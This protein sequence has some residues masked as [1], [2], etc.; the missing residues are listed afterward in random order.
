MSLRSIKKIKTRKMILLIIID[1]LQLLE[2]TRRENRNLEISEISRS[3]KILAKGDH[4]YN[5]C[6]IIS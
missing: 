3:L 4:S 1:Y 6:A 5:C 2:G